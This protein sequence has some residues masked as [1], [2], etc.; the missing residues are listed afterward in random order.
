VNRFYLED[1]IDEVKFQREVD[2]SQVDFLDLCKELGQEFQRQW[3]ESGDYMEELLDIQ[4]K[5]IMGFEKET[6]YFKENIRSYLKEK[7]GIKSTFPSWYASLEEG[8]YHE[9]WGM[10]S[11]AQW[12]SPEH[13]GSAS[14]KVIGNRI[15]FMENGRMLLKE[16]T[17]SSE[18]RSQLIGALLLLKP[19]ER[20]NRDFHEI[21]LLDG[22][23]VTIFKGDMVKKDQDVIIFR[24]YII[25]SYTFEEQGERGTIPKDAIPLLKTMVA[26]GFNVAFLGAVRTAKTTFLSTWQS[27]EEEDLEGVL[28]ETDP[29]IPLHKLMPKAPIVQLIADNEKLSGITKNLMR[30]DADYFVMGEA[31]EGVA[32]D[33]LLRITGKGTRRVKITYHC[34]NPEDFPYEVA[35]EI[36]KSLGGDQ[37]FIAKRVASAFDYLFH[38]VQLRDKNQKRLKSISEIS[39]DREKSAILVRPICEF[40][41]LSEKW[42]FAPSIGENKIGIALQ[43]NPGKYMEFEKIL[44]E[45]ASREGGVA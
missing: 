42:K 18:R 45:L 33:T 27:Y 41:F 10:A 44:A 31:R 28:V 36:V 22:T 29:E 20:S 11:L 14:A 9:N 19:K 24:R 4:K 43:E 5:A 32:L 13:M 34:G 17:I 3:E 23:R 16:Q 8:I 35:A 2:S 21:Y 26:L 12:F 40:D 1:Q 30:S 25:P 15:Y 39:L 7:G 38:F 6:N 37:D